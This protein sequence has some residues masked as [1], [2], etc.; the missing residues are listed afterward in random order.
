MQSCLSMKCFLPVNPVDNLVQCN[1]TGKRTTIHLIQHIYKEKHTALGPC[2]RLHRTV[3]HSTLA[4][5]P[6]P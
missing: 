5:F 1:F 3:K 4:L 6:K 2:I